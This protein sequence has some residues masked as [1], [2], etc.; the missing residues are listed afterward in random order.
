VDVI[1]QTYRKDPGDYRISANY[2]YAMGFKG[3]DVW[4]EDPVVPLRYAVFASAAQNYGSYIEVLW[5]AFLKEP[6]PP[7]GLLRLRYVF[8]ES[9]AGLD[10]HPTGLKETPRFFATGQWRVLKPDAILADTLQPGFDA[11][12][13][14]LL[15]S[16]PGIT[17]GPG[18]LKSLVKWE[19]LST[20]KIRI[21]TQVSQPSVLIVADNYS[22]GWE[23]FPWGPSAQT[24][25]SV[26]PAY[27]FLR[28]IPL[29]AGEHH[30]LLE[31]RPTAFVIGK[32]I[33]LFSWLVLLV[34]VFWKRKMIFR[35]NLGTS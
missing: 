35:K 1:P 16:E 21:D 15:E 10:V 9:P 11:T 31:Y 18:K 2:G 26:I 20:D 33:S 34:F 6:P 8:T 28:A 13:E 24:T 30:I 5:K 32:W 23:A 7:L 3:Y 14:A 19:D 29:M 12:R 17:P 25:Y 27:G 4:G 22:H